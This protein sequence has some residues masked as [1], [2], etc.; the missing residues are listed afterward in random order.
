M[1]GR[2]AE[3]GRAHE[4][5][6]CELCAE[7]AQLVVQRAHWAQRRVENRAGTRNVANATGAALRPNAGR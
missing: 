1:P 6:A 7:R 2:I 5:R 3:H 4:T